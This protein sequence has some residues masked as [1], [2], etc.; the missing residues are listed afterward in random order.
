VILVDESRVEDSDP[1]FFHRLETQ[2][3]IL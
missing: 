1:V 2:F 3:R